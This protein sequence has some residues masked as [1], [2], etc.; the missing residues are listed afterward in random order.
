MTTREKLLDLFETNKGRYFSGEEIAQRFHVS[1][2]AVWKAVN[3]LR[4]D[5]YAI[6]AVTNR[7][8]C[9]SED[10]DIL[11]A[12]G[13]GKYLKAEYRDLALVVLP[14]AV[15]TN[16][17]AREKANQGCPEGCVVISNA[18][19]GGRGRR[20]RSFFSPEDTGIYMS[21]LLRPVH[22]APQQA[23]RLTAAAAVAMCEAIEAVSGETAWIKW[24]NDIFVRGKKVCGIL[25]EASF[26]LENGAMEYAVLGVGV[27]VYPPKTGF[28][29]EL[30][31][32]AGTVFEAP[33]KDAK[34]ALVGEF[35][36]RFLDFYRAPE[37]T[38][39]IAHYR[40]R[41]LAVGKT[42]MVRS[43][44]VARRAYAYGVDGECRLLVRFDN[45]ETESL[46]YGEI[47]IEQERL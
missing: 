43:G 3:A 42:V 40:A 45:A 27:N 47:E 7:G 15:S 11:S 8:Y 29:P 2:A 36:N 31:Q 22:Y 13:V 17:L 38:G 24:V 12:Q 46:S 28:P 6:D 10:T 44:G 9:L 41:S 25:T 37:Q 18:Q 21:V 32:V 33:R 39:Y 19:T 23:V 5:G 35:F 1:R 14:T 34:N 20:G 4:Q 26:G 16:A 30:A